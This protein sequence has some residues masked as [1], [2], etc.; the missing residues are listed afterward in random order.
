MTQPNQIHAL[1]RLQVRPLSP[2]VGGV[3][4]NIDLNAEIEDELIAEMRTALGIYGVI[5]FENQ[6]LNPE[7]HLAFAERFGPININR[8]FKAVDGHPSVAEVLKEPDQ[9]KNVGAIWHTDHSYDHEPAMGS[10][11]RALEV[12]PTG[13]DTMFASLSAAFD[14]LSDG[15]KDVLYDLH[16]WHSSR[17]VF[18]RT[19]NREATYKGRLGNA[20]AATQDACHPVVIA[21]PI[22]GRPTLYINPQFTL[23]FDGWTVEESKALMDTLCKHVTRDEHVCRFRWKTDSIAFWDNRATWHMAL[24]DYHGHRRLMHRITVEGVGLQAHHQAD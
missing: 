23:H 14:S 7:S 22:S 9:E 15:L 4:E 18:G 1:Q 12:P 19:A 24:N 20:D 6:K 3:I 2:N 16:A 11:L 8:F 10:M 17:H 5:F 13:G 21:H